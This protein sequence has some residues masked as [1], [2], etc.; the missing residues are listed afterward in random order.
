MKYLLLFGITLCVVW[1]SAQTTKPE[2][3]PVA[4]LPLPLSGHKGVSLHTGEVLVCGGVTSNGA[5]TNSSYIFSNG[6]WKQT[7]NQLLQARAYHAL[8]SVKQSNGESVV[9]AIGGYS[10]SAGNY[11]S[12]ASVE[13]LRYDATTRV[14]QW[15]SVGNLPIAAGNCAA[16]YNKH[17]YIVV[18]GGRFQTGGALQSGTAT[19]VTSR[20]NIATLAI[21]KL[22]DM[23]T[24]RSE[25]TTAMIVSATN[26]STVLSACGENV[27]TPAT[28]ILTNTT[29]DARANP[30]QFQQ[31]FAA[32]FTDRANIA[33]M[34]GGIDE[35]NKQTNRGE[36]YD[37][38]SGW[39]LMPRMQTPRAKFPMLHIAGV[40]D[41]TN[42][43][44]AIGGESTTTSSTAECELF[45]LPTSTNV[46]GIWEPFNQLVNSG[47]DKIASIDTFNLPVVSGGVTGNRAVASVEVFQPFL[48]NDENFGQQEIGGETKRHVVKVENTWLLPVMIR[49]IR[50]QSA[51]FRLTNAQDSIVLQ[52]NGTFDI[53]VR[54][55]PNTIGNRSALLLFDVGAMTDTV[56]LEGVGIKSSISVLTS[57]QD[58]L[59]R[60]VKTDTTICFYA[61]RNDGN[62]TTVVDSV[63][64]SPADGFTVVSPVGS[65]RIPPKDSLQI[66]VRFKPQ[67]RK[68]YNEGALVHIADRQYPVTLTGQGIRAFI[69]TQATLPCDTIALPVGDSV[70]IP[71]QV[72]NT[73][74]LP[75]N[76]TN[77]TIRSTLANTF[78]VR[79]VTPVRVNP[80]SSAQ[81]ILNFTAQRESEERATV[82][83]I[84]DG[85][86]VCI[87]QLCITP[88]N[89]TL[90]FNV[91][92]TQALNV[93]VGDSTT[94]DI[95][96][97]NPSAFDTLRVDSIRV[98]GVNGYTRTTNQITILPRRSTQVT[99]VIAP[100]VSS[101]GNSSIVAFTNLGSSSYSLNVTAQ[102]TMN[103]AVSNASSSVASS[104]T[105]PIRRSDAI[106]SFQTSKHLMVYNGSVLHPRAIINLNGKNYINTATS[107]V[108]QEY[109]K[110]HLVLNWNTH[111]TAPDD[112]FGVEC[113]VLRGDDTQSQIT[114]S[115]DTNNT[116]CTNT[117]TAL[118]DIQQLCG[119]RNSLITSTN[120]MVMQLMPNPV[121]NQLQLYHSNK[122]PVQFVI[123]DILG[124]IVSQITTNATTQTIDV[125]MLPA[126]IYY[127][128]LQQNGTIQL[129]QPITILR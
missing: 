49:N 3:K 86:T 97:E 128:S 23:A 111:P 82:Q 8:V 89:R 40:R 28:E 17:G 10:G 126:G 67:Q 65:V 115:S 103:L 123:R 83:F 119:G 121:S 54:F 38:K 124:E 24:P 85:D 101:N 59:V 29:W 95:V 102:Q 120:A 48:A 116:V 52:A 66:C 117:A 44:M 32:G 36:W 81:I 100:T 73:S 53:D 96:L 55:R 79:T 1:S 5:A 60:K 35:T 61:I 22:S 64:I 34:V 68:L 108:Q 12:V 92:L 91:P 113:D 57:L 18:S 46:N 56:R 31:R 27:V 45:S 4:S 13:V 114:F 112:V 98:T 16:Y 84:N 109:G 37:V 63:M 94:F 11:A 39:R 75:V 21:E 72:F 15:R 74:D 77:V 26:D 58:F 122:Q 118:L 62:D 105:I 129:T 42:Y 9:F 70:K 30:P 107:T 19:A 76:I 50:I 7:G 110:T 99:M 20:I 43:Y 104:I 2:W 47:Y 6:I 106:T 51:E 93:C 127:C 69:T 125:S 71:M 90:K 88:R 80:G 78:A 41:T 87:T 33:R 25:H 14:W